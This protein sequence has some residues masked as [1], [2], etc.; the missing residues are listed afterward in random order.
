MS[1]RLMLG[2]EEG[3]QLSS[4]QTSLL[5]DDVRSSIYTMVG[6]RPGSNKNQL[7]KGLNIYHNHLDYHVSRLET[8]DLVVERPGGKGDVIVFRTEDAHL[9]EDPK[10]RILY[11]R[12]PT[13]DVALYISQNPGT[14]SQEIADAHDASVN[15]ARY[16][17]RRLKDHDLLEMLN[18]GRRSEYHPAPALDEWVEG[19]GA[20]YLIPI[21]EILEDHPIP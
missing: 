13:R 7:A 9:W 21:E 2:V 4:I 1:V 5:D 8:H 16:H 6:E 20:G 19:P 3:R 11:G 18:V 10:T 15:M 17:L 12:S 14:S